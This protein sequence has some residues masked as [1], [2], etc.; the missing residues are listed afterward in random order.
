[1]KG[2]VDIHFPDIDQ[3]VTSAL[4]DLSLTGIGVEIA[5]PFT[6]L[7]GEDV[8]V[9]AV[10]SYGQRYALRARIKSRREHFGK[11]FMGIEF[12]VNDDTYPEIVKFVYGDSQR[13]ADILE[14]R[15]QP[16]NSLRMAARDLS[17]FM[18]RGVRG[19]VEVVIFLL[20]SK[21][22]AA[23]KA[24][25]EILSRAYLHTIRWK[26]SVTQP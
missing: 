6:S 17:F 19:I 8:R 22:A 21:S 26:R 3:T 18:Q 10:D 5:M 1:M 14:Q 20:R 7:L 15:L 23:F 12:I 25:Q 24:L 11:T 2:S 9:D 16:V 4:K 13:W